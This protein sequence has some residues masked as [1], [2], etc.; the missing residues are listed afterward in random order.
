M[1]VTIDHRRMTVTLRQ[2]DPIN[3]AF[4]SPSV[5]WSAGGMG[6]GEGG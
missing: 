1:L 6:S 2:F 5:L 3:G 4:R